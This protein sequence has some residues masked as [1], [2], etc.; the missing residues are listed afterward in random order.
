MKHKQTKP[1][2]T[3]VTQRQFNLEMQIAA[4]NDVAS[5]LKILCDWY[6]DPDPQYGGPPSKELL[7]ALLKQL[8]LTHYRMT[9][10][11]GQVHEV[12]RNRG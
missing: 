3:G 2:V 9:K 6:D 10:L 1:M 7:E 4:V 12:S 5:D 8:S 11:T